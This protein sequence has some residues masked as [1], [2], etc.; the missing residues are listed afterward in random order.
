MCLGARMWFLKTWLPV[1]H[2]RE[3]D[4]LR[5]GTEWQPFISEVLE[6]AGTQSHLF[7]PYRFTFSSSYFPQ[8]SMMLLPSSY[9]PHKALGLLHLEEP[10]HPTLKP[11]VCYVRGT[12]AAFLC[13]PFPRSRFCSSGLCF[14]FEN[15][16]QVLFYNIIHTLLKGSLLK[17]KSSS[18][19]STSIGAEQK[20][21]YGRKTE[22][23]ALLI[24]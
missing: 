9:Y 15:M 14:S 3:V 1:R 13:H 20:N 12:T 8:E 5:G 10:P 24:K 7:P 4:P 17:F 22:N 11:R 16:F 23:S 18:G 2:C 19:D 21:T 6:Y